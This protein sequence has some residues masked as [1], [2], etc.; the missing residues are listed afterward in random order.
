MFKTKIESEYII[1]LYEQCPQYIVAQPYNGLQ[2]I[3]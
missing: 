2:F 3:T 1:F